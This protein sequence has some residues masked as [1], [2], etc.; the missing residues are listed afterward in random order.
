MGSNLDG[1]TD[2]DVNMEAIAKRLQIWKARGT[3]MSMAKAT[4]MRRTRGTVTAA[5]TVRVAAEVPR[6]GM[7]T[8][9]VTETGAV[10]GRAKDRDG[11]DGS[12]GDSERGIDNHS[13][14]DMTTERVT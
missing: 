13:K 7:G 12:D 3:A 6:T 1:D 4:W 8:A 9:T 11:K 2:G 14:R 5:E 10:A